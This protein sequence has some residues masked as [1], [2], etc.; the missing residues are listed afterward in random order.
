MAIEQFRVPDISCQHCVN[1]IT[2]EV[3]AL[4][5]VQRVQVDLDSK[6]VTVEHAP[7]IT[8]VQIVAAINE[9]GYDEVAQLS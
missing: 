7:Q 8:T 4:A 3:S 9:A 5:G 2:Q 6:T 1:A